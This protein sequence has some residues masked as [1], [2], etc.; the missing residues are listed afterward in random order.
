MNRENPNAF[1]KMDHN[2]CPFCAEHAIA[3]MVEN[4]LKW[5]HVRASEL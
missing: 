5:V 4:F 1:V 3:R 2:D